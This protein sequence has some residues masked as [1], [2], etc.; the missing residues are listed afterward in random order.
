MDWE[1]VERLAPSLAWPI[2]AII[3]LPFAISKINGLI[4][5]ISHTRKLS[6]NLPELFRLTAEITR[7]AGAVDAIKEKVERII[8]AQKVEHAERVGEEAGLEDFSVDPLTV[9]K[10]VDLPDSKDKREYT[11][12]STSLYEDLARS[13]GNVLAALDGAYSRANLGVPDKRSVGGAALELTDRRRR[14][15]LSIEDAEVLAELHGIYKRYVRIRSTR[16][17]EL[18]EDKVASFSD[19]SRL[20]IDKLD[21]F[22]T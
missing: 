13:W 19:K 1:V 8:D 4:D 15:H 9:A 18:T 17:E 2:V 5:A 6:D 11:E 7:S 3:A 14:K 22:G 21:Q 10:K 12:S 20:S 16:P